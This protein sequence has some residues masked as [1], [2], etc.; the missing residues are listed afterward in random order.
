MAEV[1][2]PT[3]RYFVSSGAILRLN[4]DGSVATLSR[5]SF[6]WFPSPVSKEEVVRGSEISEKDL[7]KLSTMP[8]D[9]GF[10]TR[11]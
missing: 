7:G 8:D 3:S 5:D 4:K 6:T 1:T 10:S 2:L 9:N 11:G